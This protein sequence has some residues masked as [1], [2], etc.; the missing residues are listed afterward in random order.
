MPQPIPPMPRPEEPLSPT[1]P[2]PE[3]PTRKEYPIHREVPEQ[4][5]H[6]G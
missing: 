2:M 1:E 6:E 5:I 3:F 4:P